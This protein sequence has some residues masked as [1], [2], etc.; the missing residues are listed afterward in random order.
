MVRIKTCPLKFALSYGIILSKVF[1]CLQ[2]NTLVETQFLVACGY[3]G[4]FYKFLKW[5]QQLFVISTPR[6]NIVF[7]Q[8]VHIIVMYAYL[9]IIRTTIIL[10]ISLDHYNIID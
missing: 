7:T 1:V 4:K 9:F 8:S 2:S 3:P 6:D 5:I 10:L